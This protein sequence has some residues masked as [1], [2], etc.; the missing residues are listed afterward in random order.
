M[1]FDA[2]ALLESLPR[3]FISFLKLPAGRIPKLK[4]VSVTTEYNGFSRLE[5]GRTSALAAWLAKNGCIAAPTL[6]DVCGTLACAHHAEDY[7]A[8]A[9]W[10]DVCPGCHMRLHKRYE[11]RDAWLKSLDRFEVVDRHWARLVSPERFDLA[12]FLRGRGSQEPT[13]EQFLDRQPPLPTPESGE[14]RS[15]ASNG[16]SQLVNPSSPNSG[17]SESVE[18]P[19]HGVE[20]QIISAFDKRT[21]SEENVINALLTH[22]GSR[23]AELDSHVGFK[24]GWHLRFGAACRRRQEMLPPAPPAPGRCNRDGTPAV[25]WSGI[26]ADYDDR[27][28]AFTMKPEAVRAF[29]QLG[30]KP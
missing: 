4:P 30:L 20:R 26:L 9:T 21:R 16:V 25:F 19:A 5:R 17:R 6:C 24:R 29:A 10:I 7:F 11:Q 27:T 15:A 1:S 18:I 3:R 22:P 23:S 13:I 12:G 14:G 28:R 8:L 2:E